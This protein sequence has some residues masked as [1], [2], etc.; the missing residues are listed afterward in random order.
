MALVWLLGGER[1]VPSARGSRPTWCRSPQPLAAHPR[2]RERP[3]CA[4]RP[5]GSEA[6]S[7]V[8]ILWPCP[9]A[10]DAYAAAGRD[11]GFRRPDCPS[12]AR[13]LVFWSGTQR[14]VREAGRYRKIFV[15]RL[16]CA[17]C[18]VSHALLPAFTLAWRLDVPETIGSVV[19]EV[20]AGGG[21]GPP[22]GGAAR[23]PYTTARG[24]SPR[25]RCGWSCPADPWRRLPRS[26]LYLP[27]ARREAGGR[28]RGGG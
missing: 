22:G 1:N 28:D 2:G 5:K 15:P 16:R 20:V 25:R 24:C 12:C 8:A 17:R 19:G 6:V 3:C 4:D 18:G 27:G 26:D 9:L 23:V 21:A 10:A 14:Y 7:P 13:P 11:L